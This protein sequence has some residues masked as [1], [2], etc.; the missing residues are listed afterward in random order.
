[1]PKGGK[2]PTVV[3][4][5]LK[6]SNIRAPGDWDGRGEGGL[7][8]APHRARAGG[9]LQYSRRS[10][11]SRRVGRSTVL[12]S[13]PCPAVDGKRRQK[14]A[15]Q[16]L[17]IHSP[18]P[19]QNPAEDRGARCPGSAPFFDLLAAL[20]AVFFGGESG[21]AR[22]ADPPDRHA[23]FA[24]QVFARHPR[25]FGAEKALSRLPATGYRQLK[26][27]ERELTAPKTGPRAA[28]PDLR[29]VCGARTPALNAAHFSRDFSARIDTLRQ[30]VAFVHARLDRQRRAARSTSAP[31]HL[32]TSAP[33]HLSRHL[34]FK[35]LAK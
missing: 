35:L 15:S 24:V 14:D 9:S 3:K 1:M 31:Q 28:L 5:A 2:P 20:P 29:R 7:K 34:Q 12:F 23:V 8:R 27:P 18:P 21:A 6:A 25:V 13:G 16:P 11:E 32:S 4:L 17:L 33:Q 19:R 26:T 10:V 22:A 30:P